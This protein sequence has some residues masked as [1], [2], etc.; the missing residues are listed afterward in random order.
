[1]DEHTATS[2]SRANPADVEED[3]VY[4]MKDVLDEEQKLIC[5]ANAVFGDA[6]AN[7]CTFNMGYI[8]QVRNS[9]TGSFK[10]VSN[11]LFD[12]TLTCTLCLFFHK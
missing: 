11:H 6:E 8:R 9:S 10:S 4:T 2:T 7:A 1:M 5:D 3:M 12:A